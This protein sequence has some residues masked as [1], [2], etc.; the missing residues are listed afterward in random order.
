MNATAARLQPHRSVSPQL[1]RPCGE[2]VAR[3]RWFNPA[4][5]ARRNVVVAQEYAKCR[6]RVRRMLLRYGVARADVDDVTADVFVVVLQRLP[7]YSGRSQLSTWVLGIAHKLASDYRSSARV[8][9]EEPMGQVPEH[10]E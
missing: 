10:G 2:Q 9:R 7:S 5:E 6:A 8:R 3:Q 4:G 1:A